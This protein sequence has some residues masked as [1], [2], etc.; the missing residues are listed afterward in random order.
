MGTGHIGD[1]VPLSE[2]SLRDLLSL[3]SRYEIPMAQLPQF[4]TLKNEHWFTAPH[5][6]W[7]KRVLGSQKPNQT[8]QRT[9]SGIR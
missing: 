1:T 7:H 8:L 4:R 3:S 6:Y 5:M 9:A 2:A